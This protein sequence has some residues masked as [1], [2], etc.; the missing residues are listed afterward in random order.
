MRKSVEKCQTYPKIQTILP[1]IWDIFAL[2]KF[3]RSNYVAKKDL[4]NNKIFATKFLNMGLTPPPL[5]KTALL[6]K[7]G[8]PN[9]DD[10]VGA[11]QFGP[12]LLINDQMN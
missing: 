4:Q 8:F 7:G 6:E 1:S 2:K 11:W 3:F 10:G 12:G 5:K 9:D